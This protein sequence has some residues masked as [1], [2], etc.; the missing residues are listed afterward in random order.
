MLRAVGYT[1]VSTG[2]QAQEGI[3]LEVQSQRIAA[4]CAEQGWELL[5]IYQDT[6]SGAKWER[7]ALQGILARLGRDKRAVKPFDI[8]ITYKVDRLAR[9]ARD[10]YEV[11]HRLEQAGVAFRSAVEPHFDTTSAWGKA[12]LGIAAIFAELE[13]DQIRGRITAAL[14]RKAEKGEWVGRPPL[15]Y[16]LEGGLLF[17][18]PQTAPFVQAAFTMLADEHLPSREVGR[19]L[20][21]LLGKGP[22]YGGFSAT[23]VKRLCSNSVY[24][25][26]IPWNEERFPG[27][28]EP[29]VD[30][31][32][33]ARAQAVLATR[34]TRRRDRDSPYLLSGLLRCARCGGPMSG[35]Y[36]SGTRNA[37][38]LRKIN[39]I[40]VCAAHASS[41]QCAGSYLFTTKAERLLIALLG[42]LYR[43]SAS[44]IRDLPRISNSQPTR[45][46]LE[47]RLRTM[48]KNFERLID[49]AARNVISN[50]EL[51]AARKRFEKER[52]QVE[53]TL[54]GLESPAVS[55]PQT[56]RRFRD[57][58]ALLRSSEV[59]VQRKRDLLAALIARIDWQ[60]DGRD[61][62]LTLTLRD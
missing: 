42:E 29:L 21:A 37:S 43:S 10:F 3:S 32:L 55:V 30:T 24:V 36:H 51:A 56:R 49:M 48:P 52:A 46:A 40:Y 6:D 15:G 4:L 39:S 35:H 62:T 28:H 31:A 23:D 20:T 25:G 53:A 11:L 33:F 47:S 60:R 38:G 13:G 17:P 45:E 27:K 7:T 14:H 26:D 50:E 59:S 61:V 12:L 8:F 41:G 9:S 2:R 44:E 54:H 5:D 58:A 1:R 22:T 16:R 18:D 19:R 57:L 34:M